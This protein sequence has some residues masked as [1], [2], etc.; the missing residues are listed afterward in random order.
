M[1][2]SDSEPQRILNKI[3]ENVDEIQTKIPENIYLTLCND[4]KDFYT[5]ITTGSS[6]PHR[7]QSPTPLFYMLY[8]TLIDDYDHQ[9]NTLQTR[10][11]E[12]EALLRASRLREMRLRSNHNRRRTSSNISA[13][14]IPELTNLSTQQPGKK[15]CSICNTELSL[16]TSLTVHQRSRK[17]RRL[18]VTVQTLQ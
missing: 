1:D 18:A 15:R 17:C 14:A 9:I 8:E 13:P 6:A 4:L 2:D 5:L 16:K 7:P 11:N 10:L 12:T 3:L